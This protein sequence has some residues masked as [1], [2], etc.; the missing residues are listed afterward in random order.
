VASA[1]LAN[2]LLAPLVDP[3]RAIRLRR[4]QALLHELAVLE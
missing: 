3:L 2:E 4:Q 1:S